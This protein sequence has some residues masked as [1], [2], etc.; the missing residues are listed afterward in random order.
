MPLL[1]WDAKYS[2]GVTAMDAQHTVLFEI[3]NQLYDAMTARQDR[4]VL[5]DL[6]TRLSNF[7]HQHFAEE[8]QM[9]AA[10]QYPELEPHRVLHRDLL[11]KVE[12]FKLRLNRKELT[13]SLHL[14]NFLRDWLTRHIQQV[15]HNYSAWMNERGIV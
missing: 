6:L 5:G 12:D 13:I 9:M 15:D 2:V 7:A 1:V 3:L 10:A 11:E 8:E 4:A 14:L